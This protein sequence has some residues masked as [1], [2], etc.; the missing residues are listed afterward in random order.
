MQDLGRLLSMNKSTKDTIQEGYQDTDPIQNN[1]NI[2]LL[3][4]FVLRN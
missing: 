3:A 4:L 1:V 2:I